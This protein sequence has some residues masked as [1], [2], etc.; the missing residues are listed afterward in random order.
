MERAI[1]MWRVLRQSRVR[2]KQ[3]DVRIM[4]REKPG[5]NR[6]RYVYTARRDPIVFVDHGHYAGSWH[7]V[8]AICGW[9]PIDD[10]ARRWLDEFNRMNGRETK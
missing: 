3:L 1:S 2:R 8:F 6:R 10:E 9:R 5:P 7:E 4:P